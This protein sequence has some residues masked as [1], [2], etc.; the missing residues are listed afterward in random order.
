M[1][2]SL[3]VNVNALPQ[4]S[5]AVACVNTG[6]P[7]QSIVVMPG[8]GSNNGAVISWTWIVCEAVEELPQAS[9]AVHVLVVL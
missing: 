9:V 4:A 3:K 1:V 6:A 8:S 5:I 7:G 2:T